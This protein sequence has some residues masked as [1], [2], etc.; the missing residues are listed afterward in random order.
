VDPVYLLYYVCSF[1]LLLFAFFSTA[2][3]ILVVVA[4]LLLIQYLSLIFI[5]YCR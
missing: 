1:I 5:T 4:F 3:Y 2:L